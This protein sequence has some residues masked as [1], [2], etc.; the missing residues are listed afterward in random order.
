MTRFTVLSPI[1][2]QQRPVYPTHDPAGY[3][4]PELKVTWPYGFLPIPFGIVIAGA[5]F[6]SMNVGRTTPYS[7]SARWSTAAI[8]VVLLVSSCACAWY[9]H[10]R[11]R[12]RRAEWAAANPD[13]V[14]AFEARGGPAAVPRLQPPSPYVQQPGMQQVVVVQQ[15]TVAG[16]ADSVYQPVATQNGAT[17]Y[18]QQ[19]LQQQP[20]GATIVTVVGNGYFYRPEFRGQRLTPEQMAAG[21]YSPMATLAGAQ[22]AAAY[23]ASYG[24]TTTA[25]VIDDLPSYDQ[26]L[27]ASTSNPAGIPGI[28]SPM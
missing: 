11:E 6:A 27:L 3:P 17:F 8:G 28:G 16:A 10:V 25:K 15:S 18:P 4:V 19:H 9:L 22:P 2:R 5:V 14:R 26:A 23:A 20:S 21:I 12:Q 7:D 13:A 24:A 1:V